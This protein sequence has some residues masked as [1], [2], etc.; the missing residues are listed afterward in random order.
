MWIVSPW[1]NIR[2]NQSDV[3]RGLR[4]QLGVK[5][6]SIGIPHFVVWGMFFFARIHWNDRDMWR[7]LVTPQLLPRGRGSR[8][9]QDLEMLIRQEGRALGHNLVVPCFADLQG[10][11]SEFNTMYIMQVGG[12]K[13]CIQVLYT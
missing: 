10:V 7:A 8:F 3:T 11:V 4:R 13:Q 9:W 2:A 1:K 6:S 12:S 5:V